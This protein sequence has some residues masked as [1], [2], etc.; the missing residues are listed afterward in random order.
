[1][2]PFDSPGHWPVY[3]CLFTYKREDTLSVPRRWREKKNDFPF[4]PLREGDDQMSNHRLPG[5]LI[6]SARYL[7]D[8][9][10][11]QSVQIGIEAV[12]GVEGGEQGE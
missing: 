11:T 12:V 8:C 10:K 3:I 1:M 7:V 9:R 2:I 6:N 4:F 5:S